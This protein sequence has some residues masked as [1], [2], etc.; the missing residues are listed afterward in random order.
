MDAGGFLFHKFTVN[1][2]V[3]TGECVFTWEGECSGWGEEKICWD[4][5][6]EWFGWGR[7]EVGGCLGGHVSHVGEVVH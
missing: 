2:A 7:V 4:M 1:N 5:E 3:I 6:G